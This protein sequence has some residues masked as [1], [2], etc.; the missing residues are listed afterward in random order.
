MDES[1][2]L[3]EGCG[4]CTEVLAPSSDVPATAAPITSNAPARGEV[5]S[6]SDEVAPDKFSWT[7]EGGD[8]WV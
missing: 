5:A 6:T 3:P 4:A 2:M 8:G 1:P 7:V